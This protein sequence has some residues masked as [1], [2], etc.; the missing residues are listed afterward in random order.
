MKLDIF[1]QAIGH[2]IRR[3]I[4]KRLRDGP[5]TAGDLANFHDVSKP[6]MSEHFKTLKESGLIRGERDGNH[7]LYHLNITVAEEAVALVVDMFGAA[8]DEKND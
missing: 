1:I 4:L 8:K 6:T 2:P 7:I 5:L 3:D